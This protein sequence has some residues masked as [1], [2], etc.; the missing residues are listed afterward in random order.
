MTQKLDGQGWGVSDAA[1]LVDELDRDLVERTAHVAEQIRKGRISKQEADYLFDLIRDVRADLAIE[2]AP[3]QPG[4]IRGR[5]AC[6]VTW[7]A[8]VRWISG[9]LEHRR[10][11]LPELVVKG[12]LTEID[13]E[14]R[15]WAMEQLRRLYWNRM[16]QWEAPA[17]PARDYLDA[18]EA[19]A[20]SGRGTAELEGSDGQRIY[21]ELVRRHLITVELEDQREPELA[22]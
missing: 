4:E 20:R 2:F 19:A 7:Q 15:I 6:R 13:C 8:K 9:E 11:R 17:G 3:L 10:K 14:R 22:A 21:R 1:A 12:R 18:L 5:H 16:F